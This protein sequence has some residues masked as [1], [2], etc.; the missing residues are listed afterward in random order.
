MAGAVVCG[1][2]K[3]VEADL[4]HKKVFY[5]RTIPNVSATSSQDVVQGGDYLIVLATMYTDDDECRDG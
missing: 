3:K 2:K 4:G 5:S 1:L